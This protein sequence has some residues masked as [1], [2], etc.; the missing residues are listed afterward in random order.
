[1]RIIL[2]FLLLPVS[3]AC[4]VVAFVPSFRWEVCVIALCLLAVY[5]LTFWGIGKHAAN[6]N[7]FLSE[8]DKKTVTIHYPNIQSEGAIRILNIRDVINVEYYKL[9]SLKAWGMLF[10]Y[11]CPQCA[12][13]SYRCNGQTVCQHI[14]YPA[15]AELH[16]FCFDNNIPLIIK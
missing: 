15:F 8:T 9:S 6:T 13:I 16:A 1:M 11:M 5:G 14:G 2:S 7:Y 12:F 3:I 4:I 10:S